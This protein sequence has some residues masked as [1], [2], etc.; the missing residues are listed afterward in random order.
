MSRTERKPR[1]YGVPYKG[2]KNQI[3]EEIVDQLP[4]AEHF[5]DLFAGGCAVSHAALLSGRYRCIHLNDLDGRG[6]RLFLNAIAGK[7][8]DERRW[9]SRED[10]QRLKDSDPYVVLCWS[11]GNDMR[12]YLYSTDQ[13]PLKRQIH[14]ML[15]ADSVHERRMAWYQLRHMLQPFLEDPRKAE[16]QDMGR[17]ERIPNLERLER[18]QSLEGLDCIWKLEDCVTARDYRDVPILPDSVI[19]CDPPYAGTRSTHNGE[20]GAGFDYDSFFCWAQAQEA[21]MVISEYSMPDGFTP[22]WSRVKT[23][24]TRR[25]NSFATE[26]LYVPDHQL[27][28]WQERTG[29]ADGDDSMKS[30]KEKNHE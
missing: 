21:L 3:A 27:G 19:Y 28:L 18:I 8:R 4:P 29:I 6:I 12:G 22:V 30:R 23:V 16:T 2:S 11:F 9:I 25:G 10:F 7:Y 5:Y 13:E 20:Y 15:T 24:M 26:H 1:W 17:L 14:L